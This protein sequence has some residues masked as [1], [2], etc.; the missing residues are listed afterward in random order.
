MS[1]ARQARPG[2]KRL[3][4]DAAIKDRVFDAVL[5]WKLDRF[6]RSLK[7]CL[8]NLKTLEENG[9]VFIAVTQGLNTSNSD[10]AGR[11]LLHILRAAA[12][13]ERS[14]IRE[15]VTAGIRAAKK[16]GKTLGRPRLVFNRDQVHKLHKQGLSIR[17]ICNRMDLS[18]GTVSRTLGGSRL[19]ENQQEPWGT[20]GERYAGA[21]SVT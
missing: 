14:L 6:G 12:E 8:D 5:V 15:R 4:T 10:P 13:F 17:E 19:N 7:D 9:V 1:G 16:D 3:L 20:G 11:F 21:S 18:I 2:L